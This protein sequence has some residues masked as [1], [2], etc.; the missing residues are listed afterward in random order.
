M[1]EITVKIN[2]GLLG[3]RKRKNTALSPTQTNPS[4]YRLP[5]SSQLSLS[6]DKPTKKEESLPSDGGER[7]KLMAATKSPATDGAEEAYRRKLDAIE[8]YC[9]A[10]REK[11]MKEVELKVQGRKEAM[12]RQVE[13]TKLIGFNKMARIQAKSEYQTQR[14]LLL[15][16]VSMR[17]KRGPGRR[18][19]PKKGNGRTAKI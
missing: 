4:K 2:S 15:R 16:N 7:R 8:K 17:K 3:K 6:G 19:K 12:L 9:V 1:F 14:A 13:Y 18:N 5:N 11:M 10:L